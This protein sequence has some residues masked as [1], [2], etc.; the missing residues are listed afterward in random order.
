[1][2]DELKRRE[3][4]EQVRRAEQATELLNNPLYIEAIQAMH[5][6]NFDL[7]IDSK[8]DDERERHELWQRTKVL[9]Q[10][11]AKFE[12]IVKQGEKAKETLTLLEKTKKVFRI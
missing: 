12:H 1:M 5:Q 4:Y 8:L 11:Q 2:N 9:K 3:A 10:F 7:F 6:A